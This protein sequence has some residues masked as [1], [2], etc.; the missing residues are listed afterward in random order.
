MAQH[1][2]NPHCEIEQPIKGE[3]DSKLTQKIR[4]TADSVIF[5]NNSA[6]W[7]RVRGVKRR[8]KMRHHPSQSQSK[9]DGCQWVDPQLSVEQ[10]GYRS[11][12]G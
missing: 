11:S 9:H 12:R 6:K 7:Q 1:G 4:Q 10:F 8:T 3:I 5:N 2:K